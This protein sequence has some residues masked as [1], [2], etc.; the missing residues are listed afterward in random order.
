MKTL[1]A[2]LAVLFAFACAYAGGI[3][4]VPLFM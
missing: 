3:T 2:I 1:Y 4:C